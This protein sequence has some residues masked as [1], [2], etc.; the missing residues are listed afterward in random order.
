LQEP[1]GFLER[2]P[3]MRSEDSDALAAYL[4]NKGYK[5]RLAGPPRPRINVARLPGLYLSFV[6]YGVGAIAEIGPERSDYALQV[7]VRGA[8]ETCTG[9]E[10]VICDARRGVIGSPTRAQSMAVT[11]ESDRL[12]VSFEAAALT[13]QLAA[14]LGEGVDET[15]VFAPAMDIETGHGRSLMRRIRL[16]MEELDDGSSLLSNPI[17]AVRFEQWL[18]TSLLLAQPS[19]YTARL[20]GGRPPIPRDVRRAIEYIDAHLD[21]AITMADLVAASGVAG[22]TLYQHFRD[23]EGVTPFGYAKKLRFERVRCALLDGGEITVT[24]VASRWGF[25]HLGRFSMEYRRRFGESPSATLAHARR[26]RS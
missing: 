22:R 23:F 6:R 9:G 21:G 12:I 1:S 19:N 18:M 5:I 20:Q 24:E 25:E 16:A 17:A 10:E 15:L 26:R 7:P 11:E 8:V 14:L 13:R 2:F 3:A 4:R